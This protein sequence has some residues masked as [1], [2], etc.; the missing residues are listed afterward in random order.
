MPFTPDKIDGCTF[1]LDGAYYSNA[2][3]L[4]K[5]YEHTNKA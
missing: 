2:N 5:W 3:R 4:D 1:E